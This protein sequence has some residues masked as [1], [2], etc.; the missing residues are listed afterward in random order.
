MPKK[1]KDNSKKKLRVLV[2]EDDEPTLESVVFKLKQRGFLVDPAKDGE[3][4]LA[5]LQKIKYSAILL[6]LR[7]PK[8][9]GYQFL[10][11]K[12]KDS[13]LREI[14][15]VVFS[16]LSLRV[17]IDWALELGVKGYLVK[18]HH[19]ISEI[20]DEFQKCIKE[21]SCRVDY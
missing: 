14:P 15:V 9:N 19:S 17:F 11:E 8:G 6:D 5:K 2:V 3:E 16:N 4:A 12:N 18:A 7:L 1:Q 20:A 10:E 21:G 13:N